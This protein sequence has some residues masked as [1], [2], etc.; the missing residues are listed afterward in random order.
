MVVKLVRISFLVLWSNEYGVTKKVHSMMKR[1]LEERKEKGK[2][3]Q[4]NIL[5]R[6]TRNKM[7]LK[8]ILSTT[9][10]VR[11][12]LPAKLPSHTLLSQTLQ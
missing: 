8:K 5:H 1:K 10:N 2:W 9:T 6:N 3:L 7:Q 12:N 11:Q 4:V